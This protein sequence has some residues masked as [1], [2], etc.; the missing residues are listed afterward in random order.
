M[1][2]FPKPPVPNRMQ[3]PEMAGPQPKVAVPPPIPTPL[4]H[5]TDHRLTDE[6]TLYILKL[7]LKPSQMQDAQ[8]L[9][10][11]SSYLENRNASQAARD[12]GFQ[13]KQG[14]YLR[15][16]PEIHAAI[17]ALTLKAVMK[18]GY[19]AS[20]VIERVKEIA[21]ID[22]IEF[23]NP[24]GSYKTHISQIAPEARRAIKKFKVKNLFGEDA[25]GMKTVIGQ[26]IE[27]E[28]WDKLKSLEL[29][30]REKNIMKETKK[31]EHDVTSNMANLL[32]ESKRRAEDRMLPESPKDV[33]PVIEIEGKVED[34]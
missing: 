10:F 14:V 34:V 32:L 12:A 16:R 15:S 4:V 17:E 11:I 33:T 23:E 7:H 9:R 25:N 8:L 30:G 13:S 19:D 6:E 21:G 22:P 27:V 3:T 26:L 24:D 29:L 2:P 20:E 1:R 28:L 18:Y 5:N 31:V